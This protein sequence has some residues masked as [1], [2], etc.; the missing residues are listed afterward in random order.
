V[1]SV[2]VG[3]YVGDQYVKLENR[4]RDEVN[5]MRM[6][7]GLPPFVGVAGWFPE[8]SPVPLGQD[9]SEDKA[10]KSQRQPAAAAA[11]H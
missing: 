6:D 5:E 10:S 3:F 9:S 2:I 11:A 4:L 1:G 7:R 8:R